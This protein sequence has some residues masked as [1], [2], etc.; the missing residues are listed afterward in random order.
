MRSWV[1]G[2]LT[3]VAIGTTMAAAAADLIIGGD[4]GDKVSV[5]ISRESID[6]PPG[7]AS[8]LSHNS[9]VQDAEGIER[10][11]HFKGRIDGSML[12]GS[13]TVEGNVM[14]VKGVVGTDGSVSGTVV[15]ESGESLGTFEGTLTDGETLAITYELGGMTGGLKAPRSLSTKVRQWVSE[16]SVAPPPSSLVRRPRS[17]SRLEAA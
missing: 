6:D 3:L 7:S 11:V 17:R 2:A 9:R 14:Q 15:L 10:T 1:L 5:E 4:P 8:A 12:I 16:F 13:V